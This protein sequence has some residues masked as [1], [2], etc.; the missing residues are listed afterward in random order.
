MACLQSHR[1]ALQGKQ[2]LVIVSRKVLNTKYGALEPL[3][4]Q[5]IEW[6][7]KLKSFTKESAGVIEVPQILELEW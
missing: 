2:N 4:T 1:L 3:V 7:N 5:T 6:I